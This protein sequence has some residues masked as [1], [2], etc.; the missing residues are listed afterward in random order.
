MT[1][2]CGNKLVCLPGSRSM[3]CRRMRR[4]PGGALP[5]PRKFTRAMT[6]NVKAWITFTIESKLARQSA[7]I[8]LGQV[9]RLGL[10]AC[11]F[12]AIARSLGAN[13]YG[14]FVSITAIAALCAPFAGLGAPN[15]L[16]K[17]VSRDA[18]ALPLYWG[19]GLVLILSSGAVFT[20]AVLGI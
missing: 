12:V 6:K 14:V 16:L 18:T 19:N 10:Q 3:L 20:L 1:F 7:T 5:K 9:L 4:S 17:N 15:I 2:R 11:Y 8:A 13:Q